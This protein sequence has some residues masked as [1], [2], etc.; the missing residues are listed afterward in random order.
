ME[1]KH[2]KIHRTSREGTSDCVEDSGNYDGPPPAKSLVA[3]TED[4]STAYGAERHG[5]VHQTILVRVQAEISGEEEIG[6]GDERLVKSGQ[7]TAH[8]CECDDDPS[9]V[10]R[11]LKLEVEETVSEPA[12]RL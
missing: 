1:G 6:T 2:T 3:R 9:E 7:E 11:V 10:L 4:Q 8:G 12:F 5:G